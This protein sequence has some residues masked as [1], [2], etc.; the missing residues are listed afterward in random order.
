MSES[1]FDVPPD[2]RADGLPTASPD[3]V[4]QDYPVEI[5]NIIPTRGYQMLPIVALGGS[6]GSIQALQRFFAATPA[7][8]GMAFVVILHLA[9]EHASI[10][11]EIIA[12]ATPMPVTQAADGQKVEANCVYVIPPGKF[13][14][15]AEGRLRLSPMEPERGKRVAVDMF[16]RTLADTHG[17]N[18]SAIILS[19]A[20]G[21]GALG[22]KRIKERGGL[23]VAQDPDEAEHPSMPRTAIDTGMVDWVLPVAEMPSRI[24]EYRA[25][26]K[27]LRLPAEDG[28]QPARAPAASP[29][30]DESAMREVLI[31]LRSRTG[32]DFA[33]YKRATVVRRISRRMQVNGVNT[34]ADYLGFLRTHPGEAGA[35]QQDLLI[36][37]TNFFRDRDSFAALEAQI[38]ALFAEKTAAHVVRAWVA[39]CA[40]GEEAYSLGML[41]LEQAGRMETPP[42]IQIFA[43]DLAED[44]IAVAR[45]GLFPFT[46]EADVSEE[47]LRRFFIKEHRGYRAKRE[48][49]EC[50]LFAVHDLLKDAPFSRLDL[51]TCRNLLIYLTADAQQRVLETAHFALLP[52]GRLFLGSSEAVDEESALWVPIDKKHRLYQQRPAA[53]L[54]M[55]VPIGPG[56]LARALEAQER[57]R[58]GPFIHGPALFAT[59][60]PAAG[61]VD[62]AE[63]DGRRVSWEELHLKLIERFAPPSLIVTR[64]YDIV[65]VSENAGRFLHFTGGE[66]SVNLLRV[67]HPMLRVELRAALFRAAQTS[68]P[69]E[70]FRV[71]V[72]MDGG[73][74]AVDIRVAPAQEIA[75]DYLLVVFSVRE[76]I[77]PAEVRARQQAEPV[78][79]HLEREIEQMKGRLRETVE[80]YEAGSEELKASNEELQAM[81][82]ELRS[83]AEELETSREELQ[84]VNEELSTVNSELKGKVDELS[85][86]NSDLANLMAATGVATIFLDRNL[87]ITRYTPNAASLFRLIPSDLGRPLSDL[88]HR[89]QYPDLT[90]DAKTVLETL[91]PARREVSDG[92]RWF[93]AQL[94]PYRTA[95]DRILGVVLTLA[96]VTENKAAEMTA[97]AIAAELERQRRT[98]DTALSSIADFAYTCDRSGRFIYANRPLCELLGRTI[99]EVEGRTFAELGYPPELAAKLQGEIEHVVATR[100]TVRA[101]MAFTNPSGEEGFYEYIFQPVLGADGSVEVVA[102]STRVITE[103]KLMEKKLRASEEKMRLIVENARDYAIFSLDLQRRILSW[104][105]GAQK[106]L[107]WSEQE[108][109]GQTG[110]II[111]TDDDCAARAPQREAETALH[112]GRA[113]DERWH[114]RRDGSCFWG[115]GMMMAM[116]DDAGRA[117]GFVKIFR[118]ETA[119]REAT[120][121]LE[122]SREELVAALA[123]T[124]RARAQAEAATEAK[125]H[126]LA[127]LS[128]ELR[129]PLMP[130]MMATATIERRKDLA[131]PVRDAL[132]MI[133]RNV[134]LEARFVDDLLDVTK[135]ARG[136]MELVRAP[137]DVHEAIR[138]AVEISQ[139]DLEAKKQRLAVNLAAAAHRLDGD[140]QRLQQ[141]V[142]NLLKNASKFTP[143]GGE[144][145]L[146]TW[147]AGGQLI[148]EVSDT[149]IGIE[150]DALPRIFD[151]FMQADLSITRQF[152]GLGLGLAIAKAT[153]LGHGGE[154]RAASAGQGLG[155]TFTLSL[156]LPEEGSGGSGENQGAA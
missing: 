25:V 75:P 68:T 100:G 89:L 138:H 96:D 78:V 81:N 111:F 44:V 42:A 151:P 149:G 64:D 52:G 130:V 155:T 144:I 143:G 121:A 69:V 152:G 98:F 5:D 105:V 90:G 48:L 122:R 67:V 22:I 55:P 16:F 28:P 137:M 135:I 113:A 154:L 62:A 56:T 107:G 156:P 45:E 94:L 21:D 33:P 15:A 8:S 6:A 82:E 125:D 117:I 34:M 124:E 23:T 131:Q 1:S 88:N 61:E 50:L 10:M 102:G 2:L 145:R 110:D 24:M 70:T 4:E 72:D 103:R 65:H 112:E 123:E 3:A 92:E 109:L 71:P 27:R 133:R 141:A 18:A 47:R 46:I 83:S 60:G 31:H 49:R 58:S 106:L 63:R 139:A 7:D 116:H 128:H 129:T 97:A 40:T 12:R 93:R 57:A 59:A 99:Q 79:R 148:V 38:P 51:V 104:N 39:A 76:N 9:A 32:R 66:P 85:H 36:S 115:S 77:G 140:F 132:D 119:A 30:A 74:V 101:E 127:V 95:E 80:Q 136:K 13:L 84:S 43:T 53:R 114:R 11:D 118:D 108:I 29:D 150:P 35:L 91:I 142:W 41:L 37:V 20:D 126:F 19:G 147:N 146:R 26:A 54:G 153:V 17:P 14:S 73:T 87:A 134:Q 86:A 120:E